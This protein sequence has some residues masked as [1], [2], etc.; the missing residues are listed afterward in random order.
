[1]TC[2]AYEIPLGPREMARHTVGDIRAAVLTDIPC[3]SA[4][5]YLVAINGM[6]AK[7]WLQIAPDPSA[8]IAKFD[9]E[10]LPREPDM[11]P[12]EGSVVFTRRGFFLHRRIRRALLGSSWLQKSDYRT[13]TD[14]SKCETYFYARTARPCLEWI[15]ELRKSGL[16]TC[17][18]SE[19]QP[20][21]IVEILAPVPRAFRLSRFQVVRH[22]FCATLRYRRLRRRPFRVPGSDI[23]GQFECYNPIL[24]WGTVDGREFSFSEGT[25]QRCLAGNS[26]DYY[27]WELTVWGPRIMQQRPELIL[28]DDTGPVPTRP[29]RTTEFTCK[30]ALVSPERTQPLTMRAARK[31]ATECLISYCAHRQS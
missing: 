30:E 1:M 26:T 20:V 9:R 28:S 24:I 14:P 11:A 17:S 5:E 6:I 22:G 29:A 2:P 15:A 31:I 7:G 27:R 13:F 19:D 4:D 23:Q 8:Q 25:Y 12:P 21:E 16:R 10:G 18:I 3:Y